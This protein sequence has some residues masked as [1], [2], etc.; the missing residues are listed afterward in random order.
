[1]YN[2]HSLSN[3]FC[4]L[5]FTQCL[6]RL[7]EE[8]RE[9][10]NMVISLWKHEVT[11]IMQ[12][13]LCRTADVN[14]FAQNLSEIMKEV[15]K[16]MNT[17]GKPVLCLIPLLLSIINDSHTVFNV[18]FFILYLKFV[19]QRE[20]MRLFEGDIKTHILNSTY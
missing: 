4:I 13:R 20:L 7:S 10:A 12:D 3:L 16:I 2:L 14:W 15:M 8:A 9:E 11:R 6:R 19:T 18:I 1:M 17:D 5:I